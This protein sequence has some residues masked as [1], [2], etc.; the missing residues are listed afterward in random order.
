MSQDQDA[1]R[2]FLRTFAAVLIALGLAAIS[3]III[4]CMLADTYKAG[5]KS[6][7]FLLSERFQPQGQT[8]IANKFSAPTTGAATGGRLE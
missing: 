6:Q 2:K 3:F 5:P 8:N 1:D 7:Q 4:V